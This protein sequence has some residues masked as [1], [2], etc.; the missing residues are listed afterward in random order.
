MEAPRARRR[1]R[2]RMGHLPRPRCPS[3]QAGPEVRGA[4]PGRGQAAEPGRWQG[5][6]ALTRDWRA[7]AR[8]GPNGER[9]G[10]L[11]RAQQGGGGESHSEEPAARA[12]GHRHLWP[13][14]GPQG[15]GGLARGRARTRAAQGRAANSRPLPRGGA[16]PPPPAPPTRREMGRPLR[17]AP[18]AAVPRCGSGAPWPSRLRRGQ[19]TMAHS[20]QE[21]R[22]RWL[23]AFDE[24]QK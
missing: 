19:L 17:G 18:P 12:A 24:D 16:R 7:R 5:G 3:L 10:A 23:L 4:G 20:L 9:A 1:H 8:R 15:S 2:P 22:R 11:L 21:L 14:L 13:R 6:R